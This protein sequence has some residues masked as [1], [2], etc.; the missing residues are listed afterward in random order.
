[1]A[2]AGRILSTD[3]FLALINANNPSATNP[4]ATTIDLIASSFFL[5]Y[6]INY[7]ALPLATS[8][9]NEIYNV[10]NGENASWRPTWLGGTYYPKGIYQSIAGVW[11]YVGDFPFQASQSD[12]DAGT[13]NNQFVTPLTLKNWAY[14]TTLKIS[15]ISIV[16]VAGEPITSYTIVRLIGG[17]AF[18]FDQTDENN[19][20]FEVGMATQSAILND[21]I[22]VVLNG[23]IENIGWGL[24]QDSIYYVSGTNGGITTTIPTSGIF[25]RIGIALTSDKLKLDFSEPIIII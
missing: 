6:A 1:M 20:G 9:P 17:K 15:Q 7:S 19:Y 10:L 22:N 23:V 12:V 5:P 21:P 4:F 18:Y 3:D 16:G 14:L 2:K 11:E 8:V 24:I 13:N 25:M